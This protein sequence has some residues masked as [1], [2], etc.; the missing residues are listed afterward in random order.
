MIINK[1]L[2][3]KIKLFSGFI[4]FILYFNKLFNM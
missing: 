2:A 1:K 4:V 3:F